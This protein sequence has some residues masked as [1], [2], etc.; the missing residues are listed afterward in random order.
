MQDE[1]IMSRLKYIALFIPHVSV[2]YQL[3]IQPAIWSIRIPHPILI[4]LEYKEV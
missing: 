4:C 3:H 1:V 2:T